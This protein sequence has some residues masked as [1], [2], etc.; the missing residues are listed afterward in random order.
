MYKKKNKRNLKKIEKNRFNIL[1]ILVVI[2][3]TILIFSIFK[4]TIID[5][6]KYVSKL[7][8]LTE[9]IVY[10]SSS[11]RGRIYDRNYNLLVDNKAVPV[12]YYKKTNGVSTKEEIE[13]AYNI[14][15]YI[16]IDSSNLTLTNFK[17]F[18]IADNPKLAK[19]KITKDEW[20][21][22]KN[23]KLTSMDIYYLQISRITEKDLSVYNENDKSAA[24]IY[25]LMNKG[26]SY[27]DKIIKEEGIS[28]LEY[29]YIAENSSNLFGFDVKY[30]WKRVYLYGDTFKTIL[31]NISSI[32]K[33]DKN[34]YLNKGYS[35]D[36][37]VGVSYL[38][39][40]YE[41]ILRG[42]KAVYKVGNNNELQLMEDGIRGRDIVLTID[43]NLQLEVEQILSE[44]ILRAKS[45]PNT[46][47]YNHSFVV[48]QQ[49]NTG[50]ILAMSGKQVL[51]K[52]GEYVIQDY[53][54]GII[55]SP[56][57]VGSIV[58]GASMYVGYINDVID[59]GEY[60]VDEC[61]KL[62]SVPKKCSWTTLG[63]I[64]DLTALAQSS[65]VYQ[66]KIAMRL[67]G[68]DYGYNKKFVISNDVYEKYR[69]VFNQFGLGVKTGIDLPIESMGNVGKS[70]SPDLLLNFAIGQYDT[71]TTMQLSQYMTTIASNG[72]RYQPHLL[73]EVYKSTNSSEL[74]EIDYQIE[75]KVLNELENVEYIKR[76]Q[77][78]MKAVISYGTGKNIMGYVDNPAGKTGTSESFLDTN[79]DGNVDTLTLSKTF[80]GFAPYDNP[81]MTL[82]VT[83]PDL[84]NPNNNNGFSSYANN[85][86]ARRIS[87]RY[88]ESYNY[89]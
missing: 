74:G 81:K 20:L 35:L 8:S 59:I 70:S 23:R 65:N 1:E 68:F 51:L 48:I 46:E 25:Y 3:F 64:N 37:L 29:A 60:Q 10:G 61:V 87:T 14:L 17:E 54:P 72:S 6:D 30:S 4:I 32:T 33:E 39:K 44:E 45:E 42:Q 66:F 38:E 36:E 80:A 86:I 85:R 77:E 67:A 88:F 11:P 2:F 26:Y 69:T 84:I 47:Y 57:T 73:K 75:P 21:K 63:Y 55:T 9:N 56:M 19:D 18:W 82:T 78:G 5:N 43:I 15:K 28:D 89:N 13:A 27:E 31:G 12:I 71:Y 40:Q 49:P 58:K 41:D 83:S 52:N 76:I 53:T 16:E 22:H 62:Y 7:N 79:R 34:Y 50:E 24:Y